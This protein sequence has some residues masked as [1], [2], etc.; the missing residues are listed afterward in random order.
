MAKLLRA[1]FSR[2]KKDKM[3][4][5]GVI[6]M[7]VLGLFVPVRNYF[8]GLEYGYMSAFDSY[9]FGFA[10][11]T[12]FLA[13]V[14]VSLFVGREYSDGTIRNKVVVGRT[15]SAIYLSNLIVSIAAAFIIHL[16]F[17]IAVCAVGIPLFGPLALGLPDVLLLLLES[18]LM[19]VAFTAVFTL[20]GML[21]QS[22]TIVAIVSI[23]GMVVLFVAAISINNSLNEP[24]FYDA[25]S[26]EVTEES[27]VVTD[28]SENIEKE[29]NPN[30][31]KPQERAVYE[32]FY[33]FL[34]TGQAMQIAQRTAVHHWQMQLYSLSIIVTTTACGV[35]FFRR[36][37]L[38]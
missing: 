31:L 38:K 34:P 2:L 28:L 29:P 1:G 35:F 15:R 18:I 22:R 27:G 11:F 5:I 8:D 23:L 21:I 19:I 4:W 10:Y 13:A 16:A 12:G 26:Y 32:F 25:F 17:I 14:F 37:D 7:L 33:D 36:K 9:F 20:L 24:E 3:L 6:F 30:Y